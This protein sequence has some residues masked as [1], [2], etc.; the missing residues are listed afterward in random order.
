MNKPDVIIPLIKG[1]SKNN[2]LE[3]L[4][5]LRSIEKHLTNYRNIVIVGHLPEF[6]QS[7]IHIPFKDGPKK[8]ANI[9]NKIIAAFNDGRVSEEV[10]FLNDD[11]FLLP[12]AFNSAP[13][14]PY[15]Y[16]GDL[17]DCSEKAARHFARNELIGAGLPTKWFDMH[18]PIRFKKNLFIE[19]A[20][21]YSDEASVKSTY[22][23][24]WMIDG[25]EMK[26][27][28]INSSLRY[29][30]IKQEIEG[31]V[32]FSVGDSGM[33]WEMKKVLNELY[34]NQSK[35]ELIPNIKNKAA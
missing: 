20:R 5:C 10:L 14:Y 8:Q 15:L 28:K 16:F 13:D 32:Y 4:F 30:R 2:D 33:N 22:C 9:R 3:L 27:L 1:G 35:F 17:R 21:H 12:H 11:I 19:A 7:V 34:P 6:V 25:Q 29:H 31:R 24:H 26:D 23:N 18:Q